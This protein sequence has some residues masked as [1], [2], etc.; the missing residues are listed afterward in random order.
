MPAE[1]RLRQ[2][3]LIGFDGGQTDTTTGAGGFGSEQRTA[4]EVVD[5]LH[6]E[7]F[8]GPDFQTDI[9]DVVGEFR[10]G[11]TVTNLFS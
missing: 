5:E 2:N 10:V 9:G 4:F 6:L 7:T 11:Q 1:R 8:A 3:E